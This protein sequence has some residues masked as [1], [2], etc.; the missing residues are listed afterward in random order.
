[1]RNLGR[2]SIVGNMPLR[3]ILAVVFLVMSALQPG[4][5]AT[6]NA[7][8]FHSDAGMNLPAEEHSH[9][10]DG[11]DHGVASDDI[12]VS[13]H[14]HGTKNSSDKS[15]EVHCAPVHAVPVDCPDLPRVVSRCF[16][17]VVTQAS[18]GGEYTAHIR[19]PRHL[20]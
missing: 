11:H 12:D 16:A 19:P 5:F 7:T 20:S 6:A 1:M 14:D 9:D 8:G 3:A 15:C 13:E 10:I 18:A 2:I 17:A 4:L